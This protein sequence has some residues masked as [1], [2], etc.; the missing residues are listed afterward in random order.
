MSDKPELEISA[1]KHDY[2]CFYLT[3]VCIVGCLL[4]VINREI[5]LMAYEPFKAD[6]SVLLSNPKF[7]YGLKFIVPLIMIPLEYL[8]YDFAM[9]LWRNRNRQLKLEKQTETGKE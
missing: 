2:G 8:V 7:E 3:I 9:D 4:L 6:G 5:V 1:H